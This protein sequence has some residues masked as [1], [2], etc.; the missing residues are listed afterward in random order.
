MSPTDGYWVLL[1]QARKDRGEEW[2]QQYMAQEEAKWRKI[3]FTALPVY[4]L[5]VALLVLV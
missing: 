5:A 1:Q 3:F 2:Y 4:L